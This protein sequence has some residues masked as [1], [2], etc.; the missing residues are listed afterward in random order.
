MKRRHLIESQRAMV[1]AKLATAGVGNP[2]F[3]QA[4]LPDRAGPTNSDA[5]KLLSVSERLSKAQSCGDWKVGRAIKWTNCPLDASQMS[6]WQE[7]RPLTCR[8]VSETQTKTFRLRHYGYCGG[9]A[10]GP[11]GQFVQ[12]AKVSFAEQTAAT[13]TNQVANFAT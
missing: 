4:N 10:A 12:T 9:N 3:N 1:G 6:R 13:D 7:L 2:S 11:S 5:A 8:W